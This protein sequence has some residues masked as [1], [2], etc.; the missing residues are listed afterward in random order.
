MSEYYIDNL[1]NETRKGLKETALKARHTGGY[2]P[3]GYDVVNQKYVINE[4]EAAFVRKMFNAAQSGE[5][6]G[7]VI[8]EMAAAGVVGKRGRSIKYPQI[9]E[10]LR[11]EKYTGV[12]LYSPHQEKKRSER[13][14]KANA[15]RVEDAIPAIISKEQFKEVQII[16]KKRK[17][18][19]RKKYLCSG[20]VYCQCG[21]KMYG[22]TPTKNGH[23]YHYYVCSKRCGSPVVQEEEVNSAAKKYLEELLN[24]ENQKTIAA[25]LRKYQAGEGSRM[26]EFY[27]ILNSKI[28]EKQN[29]YDALMQNLSSS[30]LPA[31]VVS[32]IGKRMT[33]LKEEIEILK[34]TEAPKD[35][36]VE[37]IQSWLNNLKHSADRDAIKLLIERID[38]ELD[39]NE[40]TV[41][42]I[43]STLNTVVGLIGCGGRI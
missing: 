41:F 36:T 20:L 38:V 42:N 2:P 28:E 13:R 31:D 8:K 10:I 26:E 17:N 33:E 7:Q 23:T 16:M 15:I 32:D 40:K 43:T 3:F 9:Y 12:Y 30:A 37:T 22:H 5:G 27:Q 25:A 4:M 39:E 1:A 18:L 34:N 19:N 29:Q 24:E 35:F 11:N 6:F 14:T 21:A